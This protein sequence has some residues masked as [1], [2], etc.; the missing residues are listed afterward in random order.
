VARATFSFKAACVFTMA[1]TTAAAVSG[2]RS[3]NWSVVA[4]EAMV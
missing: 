3:I 2:E 4:I 1:R